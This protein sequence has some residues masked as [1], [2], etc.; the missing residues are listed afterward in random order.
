MH[1]ISHFKIPQNVPLQGSIPFAD[2]AKATELPE[3]DVARL[4]R[5][6]AISHIFV[7]SPQ[8]SVAHTATSALLAADPQMQALVAHMSEEAFPASARVVDALEKTPGSGEPSDSPFA[9]AFGKSFFERKVAQ[10]ETMQ[11][12][13]L[14][15]SSWSEGDGTSQMRDCYK[16]ASLPAGSK[17]VDVGG[18]AGHISLGIAKGFENLEFI[19]EDQPP[20]ADQAKQ[21]I[22]SQP[23]SVSSRVRFVPHDFFQPHP[24]EAVGADIYIMR[25]ILHD[26]SDIYA[27]KILENVFQ[28]MGDQSKLLIADAVLPPSGVLP[29]CQ[30]EVLRS[31]DIVSDILVF[32]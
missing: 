30:E 29:R 32:Q 1:A 31:F 27:Q 8:G 14:A 28:V 20:L 12:F 5:R 4:V 15:M 16:W 2:L 6:T 17:V 26:W 11:R 19:V 24:A 18:A 9:L 21:L 13:G 25:Y 23:E 10:P 7:E 22:S 3:I